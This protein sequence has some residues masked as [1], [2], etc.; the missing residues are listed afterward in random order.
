MPR[1]ACLVLLSFLTGSLSAQEFR[2]SVSGQITDPAGAAVPAADVAVTNLDRNTSSRVVSNAAGRYVLEFLS[3]G[4]YTLTVEKTGFKKFVRAGLNLEAADHVALN[5]ALE[6]GETNQSVTVTDEPPLLETETA[7]RASTIE[8]RVLENVPTNGRNLFSLQYTEPGV[9]K[10]ST[11]WGSMELWAYSDV[12]GV[13]INGGRSGE[14]ETLM[15]GVADTNANRSVSLMPSLS[16]TQEVT[17]LSNIYDAQFGRFG[18]GVTSVSVKSG[19]NRLHGEAY[20]FLKNI[21]LD[22]TDALNDGDTLTEQFGIAPQLATLEMMML[23]KSQRLLGG[24]V[25]ALLGSSASRFLCL[26]SMQDPPIILW[27]WGR[28]KILPVNIVNME[29]KEEQYATDLNPTRAVVT[30]QL[31]VIEGP[32]A[33]YLYSKAMQEVM[34]ALNLAHIGDLSKTIVPA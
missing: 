31:E 24:A 23:P 10:Q 4:R 27:V 6:I 19:T 12:N 32:N 7:S 11:Y 22:A 5:V 16:G 3:P 18:G 13:S 34:G 21:R 20:E 15:D 25:S 33:P 26:E 29:I 17:V 14:N 9:I 1:C 8:N 28:K 30:V 2:A